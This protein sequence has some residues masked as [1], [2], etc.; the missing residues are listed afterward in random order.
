[1]VMESRPPAALLLALPALSKKGL[2]R[3]SGKPATTARTARELRVQCLR[4]RSASSPSFGDQRAATPGRRVSAKASEATRR[5]AAAG[6][7]SPSGLSDRRQPLQRG[8]WST[9]PHRRREQLL[10]HRSPAPGMAASGHCVQHWRATGALLGDE[11]GTSSR[12]SVMSRTA[13]VAAGIALIAA[14]GSAMPS[15][16]SLQSAQTC[17]QNRPGLPMPASAFGHVERSPGIVR[18][19][20]RA[21]ARAPPPR[22]RQ[23]HH[24]VAARGGSRGGCP[25][26]RVSPWCP[27]FFWNLLP[28]ALE[29]RRPRSAP[30]A[31]SSGERAKNAPMNAAPCIR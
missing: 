30:R 29:Q 5:R 6:P 15:W 14:N 9:P 23:R 22:R 10:R 3:A 27:N 26:P 28:D 16:P 8:R 7:R 20:A 18:H 12:T 13:L 24:L 4:R 11:R 17:S 2:V 25:P 19:R 21:V 1:M 31:D